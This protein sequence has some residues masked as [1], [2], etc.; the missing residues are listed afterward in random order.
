M[1]AEDTYI[2][3]KIRQLRV[4][5]RVSQ[6]ELGKELGTTKQVVSRIEKGIRK[7]QYSELLKIATFLDVSI[8]SFTKIDVKYEMVHTKFRPVDIPRF[9]TEF[10]DDFELYLRSGVNDDIGMLVKDEIKL[11]M[12]DIYKRVFPI[13]FR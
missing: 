5:N 7:V 6:D 2:G 10:L 12:D 9:S 4:I 3:E 13:L 8:E 11:R 1:G